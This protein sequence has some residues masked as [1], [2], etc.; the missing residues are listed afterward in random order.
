MMTGRGHALGGR[1]GEARAAGLRTVAAFEALKGLLVLAAGL[2][3]LSLI[4]RDLETA[5]DRLLHIVH[6]NPDGHL[7]EIF[8][9]AARI[10]RNA[11]LWMAA[12]AA[13]AYSLVRFIEAYGLWN[14]RV[15][16]EWFAL[17]SAS[18]YLPWEVLEAL[19]HSGPFRWALLLSN[20]AIVLYMARRRAGALRKPPTTPARPVTQ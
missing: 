8:L 5:A 3:L 2:G 10:M 1:S 6:V 18:L 19:R 4:H 11:R 9:R 20:L 7:G 15:W 14:G 12:A 13:I 17:V 16:A